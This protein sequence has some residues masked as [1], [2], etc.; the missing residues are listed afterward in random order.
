MRFKYVLATAVVATLMLSGC[1]VFYPN[2]K[3]TPT[4]VEQPT[5]TPEPTE[6]PT[7]TPE[8]DPALKKVNLNIID[9][10]AF[11]DNGSID[12]IAEALNILEDN[13]NCTLTVSQGKTSQSVTVKAESNVTSTQCFPLSVPVTGFKKGE[14]TYT[15]EY[16][17][18]KYSGT[19]DGTLTVQ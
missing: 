3:P 15:V 13:G 5:Q 9:A 2:S 8:P 10:S 7:P 18:K 12:V 1:S 19:V 4:A 6:T 11:I 16:K 17:S 14:A